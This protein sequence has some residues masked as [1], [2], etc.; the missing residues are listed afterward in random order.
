MKALKLD[1]T[2]IITIIFC[3]VLQNL[4]SDWAFV[5]THGFDIGILYRMGKIGLRHHLSVLLFPSVKPSGLLLGVASVSH[6]PLE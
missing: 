4:A 6:P 2:Q 5:P 3:N 1:M